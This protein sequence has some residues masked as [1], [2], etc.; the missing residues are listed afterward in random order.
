MEWKEENHECRHHGCGH[1]HGDRHGHGNGHGIQHGFREHPGHMDEPTNDP[2]QQPKSLSFIDDQSNWDIVKATQYGALERCKELVEAGYDVRQPDKENVS[3]LHW[4][5]INNRV[6]LVKYYISKGAIIDQLGG[7]LNSTPLHWAVRQG[8]LSTVVVLLKY[9]A[10]LALV[11]GEGFSS[12]HLAVLFQHMPI[13]A[14][15]LAKG[16]DVDMPDLNGQT[17]LMLAAQKIIGPEPAHILLKFNASVS[18]VDKVHKNTPLHWAVMSGNDNAAHFLL[19]AGADVDAQN[20]KGET[21]LH[22]AHQV[23]N[24]LLIH[25]LTQVKHERSNANMMFFRRLQRYKFHLV[26][27]FCICVLWAVGFIAD[28]NSESWLLKGTLFACMYAVIHLV[29]RR[30]MGSQVQTFLPAALLLASLFLIFVTWFVL[31]LPDILLLWRSHLSEPIFQIP[32]TV[33]LT[34]LLYFYYKSWRTDPGYIR[35]TEEDKKENVITLAEAGCLELGLFCSSCLVHRPMRS[36]HCFACDSCV[37]RHDHHSLWTNGC[38]GTGN[39]RYFLGFVFFLSLVGGWM[40]YGTIVYWSSHCPT[41]Y[42]EDGVWGFAIQIVS[43][44]P[45]VMFIFTVV[46]IHTSWS[47]LLLLTQ[48]YHIAFLGLTVTERLNI[49]KRIKRS[50]H[51]ISIRQN[52]YNLGCFKN[53]VNFF[54]L[55]CFGLFK[56]NIVDWTQQYNISVLSQQPVPG[57]LQAV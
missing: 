12:I 37:A 2:T 24:P 41:N 22:L 36:M 18:A 28:M 47:S 3:L 53:I 51:A 52:P 40:F 55:R 57:D 25:M 38:I 32:F 39:H 26:L 46:L 20:A 23:R 1:G 9:R 48:L 33:N 15:L 45:W 21:P 7:D 43:C 35:A 54:Q 4:A 5:A 17:P 13:I 16:Q 34:G 11:D 50:R 29:T 10:D 27:L 6:D 31:F 8:H 49:L 30:F 19:E 56:P 42:Q 44:S 14:Y